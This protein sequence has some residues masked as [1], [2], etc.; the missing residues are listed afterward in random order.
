MLERN[1]RCCI[2]PWPPRQK[3]DAEGPERI[4]WST[5]ANCRPGGE[6]EGTGF[7]RP[8]EKVAKWDLTAVFHHRKAVK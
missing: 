6:S 4:W 2:K 7:P 5:T 3:K 8:V 1:T